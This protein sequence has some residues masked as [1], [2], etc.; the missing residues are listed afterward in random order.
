MPSR[1]SAGQSDAYQIVQEFPSESK[2]G[3]K[4]TVKRKVATGELSC[5]CPVW[6]FSGR[7]RH[8]KHVE[9][10]TRGTVSEQTR[11]TSRAAARSSRV[12]PSP[13]GYRRVGSI[14]GY[15]IF[16]RGS[17]APAEFFCGCA[18]FQRDEECQ[19]VDG[20]ARLRLGEFIPTA[21]RSEFVQRIGGNAI[22]LIV[23]GVL[24]SP[25][26]WT[27]NAGDYYCACDVFERNGAC[28]HLREFREELEA[29]TARAREE[30]ERRRVV[31]EQRTREIERA[32][33]TER[34]RIETAGDEIRRGL[35]FVL[36]R[37]RAG[38]DDLVVSWT[39]QLGRM[40]PL[41]TVR[42]GEY[43]CTCDAFRRFGDCPHASAQ[44]DTDRAYGESANRSNI[45]IEGGRESGE[46][47][48]QN[49]VG[50]VGRTGTPTSPDDNADIER[51]RNSRS[52]GVEFVSDEFE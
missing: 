19:H 43:F 5:D 11:P 32:L 36:R 1:R 25:H 4:Y 38:E 33:R 52:G 14:G 35:D 17:D 49:A 34:E 48:E 28:L 45:G 27:V 40:V 10:V 42:A 21:Y 20:A 29:R 3:K 8:C 6:I 12:A 15:D 41:S 22:S 47:Q 50:T 13:D 7:N 44:R 30:E 2:P 18:A 9:S 26:G 37:L 51:W 23:E 39:E 31:E 46:S 24:T 16:R